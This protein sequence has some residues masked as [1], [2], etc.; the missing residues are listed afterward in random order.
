[1]KQICNEI[2]DREIVYFR[3]KV[4]EF[5]QSGNV[6]EHKRYKNALEDAIR[7]SNLISV[8]RIYHANQAEADLLKTLCDDVTNYMTTAPAQEMRR[9]SDEKEKERMHLP[10][11]QAQLLQEV[12]VHAN[13]LIAAK[14]LATGKAPPRKEATHDYGSRVLNH[15]EKVELVNNLN[16]AVR[17]IEAQVHTERKIIPDRTKTLIQNARERLRMV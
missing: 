5:K 7:R 13:L 9:E 4:T 1:L 12:R 2:I 11:Q 16:V 10:V 3:D 6:V 17:N 15:D 14:T 8:M